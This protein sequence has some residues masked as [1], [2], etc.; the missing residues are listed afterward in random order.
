[1]LLEIVQMLYSFFSNVFNSCA[2]Y[3]T[4]LS[5]IKRV[6]VYIVPY[7]MGTA[8]F[9]KMSTRLL[10]LRIRPRIGDLLKLNYGVH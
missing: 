9:L 7:K 1:M 8:I 2:H 3:E 5:A 6:K 4:C 10:T